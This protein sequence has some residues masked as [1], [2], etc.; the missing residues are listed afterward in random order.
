M[1]PMV[2]VAG[3]ATLWQPGHMNL[4]IRTV[5]RTL[6]VTINRPERRNAIDG[7]TAD[8]LHRT[9]VGFDADD[10]LDV[11]VLAGANGTFCAGADLHAIAEGN[12]NRVAGDLSEPAPLG[13]T[14]LELNKPVIA[15]VEGFAV[16]GGLE[17]ALWCDLRV[18][19]SDA[20][21]GVYC[22]RFGV[23]LIVGGTVR[24]PR[25]VGHSRAMDMILTGRSV[26]GSEAGAW[27]LANRVCEPGEAL[28]EAIELATSLSALPQTCLRN[29]RRSCNEQWGLGLGAALA[30]ET[31]L[32]LDTL[33]S[34]ESL[35]GAGRFAAGAGRGGTPAGAAERGEAQPK[36]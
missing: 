15:A 32:G 33:R 12:G 18:A 22:R 34:G 25:L 5:D 19:A 11:A 3:A 36:R 31:R 9:F 4:G 23:P 14:R 26:S 21:F 2:R 29:D 20:T 17:L 28:D 8:D 16:A 27:G 24:L 7:P 10:T 35:A 6:V 1:R 13:C 30:N